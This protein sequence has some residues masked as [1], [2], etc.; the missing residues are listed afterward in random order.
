MRPYSRIL[1]GRALTGALA[2]SAL[3]G[4]AMYWQRTQVAQPDQAV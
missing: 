1:L 3:I 4:F 2:F